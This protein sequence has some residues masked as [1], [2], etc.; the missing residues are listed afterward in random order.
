[1]RINRIGVYGFYIVKVSHLDKAL[2]AMIGS[3]PNTLTS[4]RTYK[5]T[6]HFKNVPQERRTGWNSSSRVRQFENVR[7]FGEEIFGGVV[8]RKHGGKLLTAI[9]NLTADPLGRKTVY[10]PRLEPK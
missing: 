2:E 8:P 9:N 5:M 4:P 7:F 3:R 1:V 6:P 10:S